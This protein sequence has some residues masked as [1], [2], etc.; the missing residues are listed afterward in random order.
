MAEI[1]NSEEYDRN[2]LHIIY[3]LSKDL[4]LPGFQVGVVYSFNQ[5]V[6]DASKKLL[7]FSSVSSLAQRLLISMVNDSRF[8]GKFIK[9][10]RERVERMR[11]LFVSGLK[12][13]GIEC[14]ES[15]RGLYCWADM[16]GFIRPYS[17]KGEFELWEKLLNVGKINATPGSCCH[18]IEPGW[19]RFCFTNLKEKE[20]PLV[21]E[22][23]GSVL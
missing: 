11:N 4:S 14:V 8:V 1:M 6:M 22:R 5:N 10:N 16:S 17:E 12:N 13:L 23:I 21:M 7:R 15:S 19:F 2:R 20:I 18:C 3:E 9:I